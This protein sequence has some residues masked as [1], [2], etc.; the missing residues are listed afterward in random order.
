MVTTGSY[1]LE[2]GHT[3][4]LDVKAVTKCSKGSIIELYISKVLH[5]L[6]SIIKVPNRST[7]TI[8]SHIYIHIDMTYGK[9]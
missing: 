5:I 4:A 2:H 1:I 9:V 8:E 3:L 6:S 7:V